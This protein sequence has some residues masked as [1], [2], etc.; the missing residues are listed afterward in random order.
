MD[1]GVKRK[2]LRERFQCSY[3]IILKLPEDVCLTLNNDQWP[4]KH[5][6]RKHW[7][8]GHQIMHEHIPLWQ[9]EFM[10][11][12]YYCSNSIWMLPIK[13]FTLDMH[14]EQTTVIVRQLIEKICFVFQ[15]DLISIVPYQKCIWLNLNETWTD[16]WKMQITVIYSCTY[17][18]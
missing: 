2:R 14:A 5:F 3:T 11:K 15:K 18:E 17:L 4:Q 16:M 8:Y 12:Y 7:R 1:L 10:Y 13:Y 6:G 9:H